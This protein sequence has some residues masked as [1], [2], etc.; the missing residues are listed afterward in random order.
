MARLICLA[1][2]W[3]PGGRCVAGIDCATGQ[4]VRPV[5]FQGGAIREERTWLGGRCI[6]PLDM[7]EVPLEAPTFDTR[8]Q[9]ENCRV[10][11]WNW[12]HVGRA[13]VAGVLAYCTTPA[14]ILHSAGK[15]V[16]PA[17]MEALPPQQWTSLELVRAEGVV[18]QRD[19]HKE[20][21]WQARFSMGQ[22][23]PEYRLPVTDPETTL[24]LGAGEQIAS[25]CLLT[26][27]L[28]EPIEIGQFNKPKLCYK[29]VAGVIELE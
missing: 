5:P 13:E 18:F 2:S 14:R 15:I 9:R 3:R 10:R 26:V 27:S 29:L 1:N 12:R 25:H 16:E 7:I 19:P 8:F 22:G 4:W 6:A 24:R 21:R 20:H 17:E 23:G 28:T 11:N